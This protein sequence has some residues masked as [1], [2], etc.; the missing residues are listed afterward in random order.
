IEASSTSAAKLASVASLI[1]GC[2]AAE[3]AAPRAWAGWLG[4]ALA[5]AG[6]LAVVFKG[7]PVGSTREAMMRL[8]DWGDAKMG[9]G[10]GKAKPFGAESGTL[11]N[12]NA[13]WAITPSLAWSAGVAQ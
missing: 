2:A 13:C 6:S 9:R 5:A 8:C 1:A 4:A 3:G 10:R 12:L 7:R 11:L